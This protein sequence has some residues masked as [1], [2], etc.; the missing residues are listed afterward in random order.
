MLT[1][2]EEWNNNWSP[3]I[4][5]ALKEIKNPKT[6][7]KQI[8]NLLTASR[9]LSPLIIIPVALLNNLLATFIV[10]ALFALTDAIDG[11]IARKFKVQS[12]LGQMLDPVTDKI[13]ALS[14]LIP[15]II[16]F[17]LFTIS[18]ITLEFII[19]AINIKSKLKGNLP[20][21]NM[22]GKIKTTFLS[23]TS[24]SMYLTK[25]NYINLFIPFLFIITT[26]LQIITAI[27]YKK[28]DIEKDKKN[29]SC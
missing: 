1:I 20:K 21:S 6:F 19:A 24:I 9:L 22:I 17:P 8:P 13:F 25:I 14:L 28:I 3:E 18:L 4:K 16:K 23:I 26:I 15:H 29:K 7:Y 11:K 12:K 27:L 2:K 5:N 10:T